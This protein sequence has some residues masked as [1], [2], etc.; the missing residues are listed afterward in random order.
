M[1]KHNIVLSTDIGTDFDDALA[2]YLCINSRE[3]DV[4]GIYVTNGNVD[5]RA[6]IA[7]KILRLAKYNAPVC[8]GEA[9]PLTPDILPYHTCFEKMLLSKKEYEQ[10]LEEADIRIDGMSHLEKTIE[11]T[12]PEILS[13]APLTNLAV[14]I[15]RNPKLEKKVRNVYIMGGRE[16]EQEH[17]FRHDIFAAQLVFNSSLPIVVVP[18]DICDKFRL[19]SSYLTKLKRDSLSKYLS[20][21]ASVWNTAKE[22]EDLMVERINGSNVPL[23]DTL[24]ELERVN[25]SFK[26]PQH[27]RTSLK[28]LS[29]Y[30]M[31][32]QDYQKMFDFYRMFKASIKNLDYPFLRYIIGDFF[33]RIERKEVSVSDAYVIYSL[34]HP[35]RTERKKAEIKI[36]D[37]GIMRVLPGDKHEI[38]TDLDYGHFREYLI[39]NLQLEKT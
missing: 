9:S 39:K 5:L 7:R 12:S 32:S 3:I 22:I 16:N 35:E 30:N 18:A 21:M 33:E 10:T 26:L 8:I 28:V 11:E 19:S 15:K 29:N 31:F 25:P 27:V 2:L 23:L 1:K 20:H 6:R 17:N 36:N 4:K 34:L 14:A 38:I 13:I 37:E 24:N